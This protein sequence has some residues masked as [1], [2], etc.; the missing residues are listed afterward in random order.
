[1]LLKTTS[2]I[3]S[4]IFQIERVEFSPFVFFNELLNLS[5]KHF[6]VAFTHKI[7]VLETSFHRGLEVR[8]QR[9]LCTSF[10]PV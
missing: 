9:V 6:F 1:M 3:D 4:E 8:F 7:R 10:Q 2:M 5:K